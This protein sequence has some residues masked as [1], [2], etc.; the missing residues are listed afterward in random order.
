MNRQYSQN[1]LRRTGG[2]TLIEMLVA[3]AIIAILIAV[4]VPVIG[5]ANSAAE[6]AKCAS[7]LRQI[8][9]SASLYSVDNDGYILPSRTGFSYSQ[10]WPWLL[11]SQ[12]GGKYISGMPYRMDTPFICKNAYKEGD[13]FACSAG[14]PQT[15]LISTYSVNVGI[16]GS[17]IS[18]NWQGVQRKLAGLPRPASTSFCT[19]G[20]GQS[21]AYSYYTKFN[22]HHNGKMNIV[23]CD[24]HVEART[25]EQVPTQG[26]DVFFSGDIVNYL[27]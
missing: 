16:C 20:M 5:R 22:Y 1:Q 25:K 14:A 7:N 26:S 6:E 15:G 13:Y 12:M 10:Y 21:F 19:D 4:M 17:L 2:F 23:F 18:T 8:F 24:G 27:Q 9:T 11:S 3:I